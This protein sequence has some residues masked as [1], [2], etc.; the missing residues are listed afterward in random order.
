M[1]ELTTVRL[2]DYQL[3][4][5]TTLHHDLV[6]MLEEDGAI[7][8]HK[9]QFRRFQAPEN[10]HGWPIE[11]AKDLV[12]D[13][14]ELTL[15]D[16]AING[17]P[18]KDDQWRYQNNKLTLSNVPDAFE[19][20]TKVS[21]NPDKNKELSGLY[22]S[23]GVYCTQC[24]AEGFRR[25]SFAQDRP[26][27]LATYHV[28]IE[29][30]INTAPVQL[31]NGNLVKQGRI[32][33]KRHFSEWDDPHP[34]PTYLFAIVAGN[35]AVNKRR[36]SI[37]N[38]QEIDLRIYTE[39]PFLDQTD[40]AMQ[41][42]VDAI[43]WD[44]KRFNLSYDLERFNIVAVSDFN[45]GAM[46]NKSLNIFNTR[47][48]LAKTDTGTDDDFHGIRSVIGHEYFHNWTGNR[49]TCRDWFQL[50]LKEGLTVFRD[51]EF[52]ADLGER[53]IER[54]GHVSCLR[55]LQ[56]PEDAGPMS[57]PVRP[58]SYAAIDNF[59][60][61]TVYEK[62]AEIIRM[63]HTILGEQAFQQ[64]M[65]IYIKR[66]DG[67][68]VRIEEFAECMSEVSDFN[69]RGQFFDWYTTKGTPG[70]KFS[71]SYQQDKH[72][73]TL[74]IAQDISKVSP[75]R[76]LVIPVRISL[77]HPDGGQY[78]FADGEYS[79]LLILAKPHDSWTFKNAEADLIP[80]I[81]Q[82][83]TAPVNYT[84]DYDD[85]ELVAIVTHADDGF[86]RYEAMQIC[87]L[88]LFRYSIDN[89]KALAE[90][91]QLLEKLFQ[92]V[93]TSNQ[94]SPQEKALLLSLPTV[95][96][97]LNVLESPVDMDA[98]TNAYNR[99]LKLVALKHRDLFNEML[100]AYPQPTS[101]DYSVADAG[102][103]ALR[104][105]C[106]RYL[107]V[108]TEPELRDMFKQAYQQANCM[109]ERMNALEALNAYHDD[110]RAQVFADFSQRFADQPLVIDK[111]FAIQAR[112]DADDT[113]ERLERL[114]QDTRFD[115][116]NP[117]RFRALLGTFAGQNLLRFHHKD[118]SGYRFVAEQI[119][120]ILAFNPQLSARMIN[121]FSSVTRLDTDRKELVA[122]LLQSLL[123][124]KEISVDAREVA[125]RILN[126]LQ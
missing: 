22:R 77:L 117:N 46:E 8:T 104:G 118:G 11:K 10:K 41:S 47:F 86:A 123:N 3:P 97:V 101:A 57:H 42:L 90:K 106:M 112:Y 6:F 9:Q 50:S 116:T 34:K 84:Y 89:P 16:I 5:F 70:L 20:M 72:E 38:Q 87:F 108:F 122:S 82:A 83:F 32:D 69:F 125:E 71:T 115:L 49:I 93:L 63:M 36:L 76:P 120:R 26:D 91:V 75:Q 85:E 45:M 61:A 43:F 94:R 80:V 56:F 105:M 59:Y 21:I 37:K 81:M 1:D 119:K 74:N 40:F 60:T 100:Q 65:A 25:I 113:I 64:G 67:Q 55:R 92:A 17:E 62:G 30:D 110:F 121:V 31:A 15:L 27:V 52:S 102:V 2:A 111:W 44:E 18:L 103:R 88:R 126:G 96:E 79:Q 95:A 33:D 109:T 28:R 124:S 51:Q 114:A 39:A 19:L 23:N 99:V 48:V 53:S 35:L 12:L 24:E 14:E 4:A 13:G 98:L 68:A 29:S 107:S 66:Y 7:V 58:T 78:Q 54:I 73:L